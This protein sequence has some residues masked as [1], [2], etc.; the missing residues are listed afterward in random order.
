VAE[1]Q[2]SWFSALLR[3]ALDERLGCFEGVYKRGAVEVVRR[4]AA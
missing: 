2:R 3:P 1:L 4:L